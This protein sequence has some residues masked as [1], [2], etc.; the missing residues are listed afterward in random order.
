MSTWGKR[1]FFIAGISII[2]LVATRFFLGGWISYLWIPFGVA[3]A[4][5]VAAFA[6]DFKFYLEFFAMRTTKHGMNMGTLIIGGLALAVVLNYVGVRFDKTFD[7]T[8]EKLFSLSDQSKKTLDTLPEDTII[9]IFYKGQEDLQAREQIKM[10][11][12]NFRNYSSKLRV[13]YVNSLVE[14]ELAKEY[15]KS[16]DQVTVIAELGKQRVQVDPPYG[17]EQVTSALIKVQRTDKKVIYFLSGHGERDIE[18]TDR[19]GI[20]ELRTG[21][22]N[23][24]FDVK[25]INLLKGDSLPSE[26]AVLAIVGPKTSF[27]DSEIEQIRAFVKAGGALFLAADPGESHQLAGL[28]KSFG[29]EFRNNYILNARQMILGLGRAAVL[30]MQFDTQSSIT[31]SF[32]NTDQFSLF[33]MASEVTK[34]PG[35]SGD[36]AI[37]EIVSTDPAAF[38]L[39]SLKRPAGEPE[40]SEKSMAVTVSGKLEDKDIKAAIF[41]DSDFLT[42]AIFFQGVNRD[43]ALNTFAYLADD[44]GLIS[45]RPKKAKGTELTMTLNQQKMAVAAGVAYP[46]IIFVVGAVIWFRRRGL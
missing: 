13:D 17:E 18:A 34:E 31:K 11:L 26:N 12:Q 25:K 16:V 42:N 15:L 30:A 37:T 38:S 4:S 9:R 2:I 23:N 29:V 27:L 35:Y 24:G 43:L 10:K 22:L 21:L 33:F 19:N 3:I 6:I 41:G 45:I 40:Q 44:A 14:N 1:S 39:D 46:L 32:A 5:I 7:L 20:T 28:T 36:L 8:E